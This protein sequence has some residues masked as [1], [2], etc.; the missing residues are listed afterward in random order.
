MKKILLILS[1]LCLFGC[2]KSDYKDKSS[3]QLSDLTNSVEKDSITSPKKG[4]ENSK[5]SIYSMLNK[6][7]ETENLS[8]ESRENLDL[9]KGFKGLKIDKR[10]S[11]FMI[12]NEFKILSDVN[13]LSHNYKKIQ[14]VPKNPFK[15]KSGNGNIMFITLIFLDDALKRLEINQ[16]ES[17]EIG[18]SEYDSKNFS[19][20]LKYNSFI[21]IFAS[22]FG[23]P[24]SFEYLMLGSKPKKMYGDFQDN[25]NKIHNEYNK[26]QNN[27]QLTFIDL[28]WKND[29]LEYYL[30]VTPIDMNYLNTDSEIKTLS[31]DSFMLIQEKASK[32]VINAID[33]Q[34]A[35][36]ENLIREKNKLNKKIQDKKN[37]IESL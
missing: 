26:T 31:M 19:R 3:Q 28:E 11:D 27:G 6:K 14:F 15:I 30:T 13:I 24:D 29:K 16:N 12:D 1:T 7:I 2:E 32:D 20:G 17:W 25:L 5:E 22:A 8:I 36:N 10:L 4:Q 21:N 34:I 23:K 37:T 18:K 33:E 9:F 35:K